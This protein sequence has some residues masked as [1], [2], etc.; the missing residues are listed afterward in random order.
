MGLVDSPELT[1]SPQN[2]ANFTS[3]N[4]FPCLTSLLA[5]PSSHHPN[6]CA[7]EAACCVGCACLSKIFSGLCSCGGG[8]GPS[9]S[10]GRT[11]SVILLLFSIVLSLVLQYMVVPH[12]YVSQLDYAWKVSNAG[13][14]LAWP[15]CGP[16]SKAVFLLVISRSHLYNLPQPSKPLPIPPPTP[17]PTHTVRGH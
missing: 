16:T 9:P 5:H 4:P 3:P 8:K 7:G 2:C 15:V 12:S 14:C 11:K 6:S 17:P 10:A 1:R 13:L